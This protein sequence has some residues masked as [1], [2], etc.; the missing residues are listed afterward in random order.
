MKRS[1]PRGVMILE[2]MMSA[3]ARPTVSTLVSMMFVGL[4]AAGPARAADLSS[5]APAPMGTEEVVE[6][7]TG[8]YLRGDVGYIGYTKPKDFGF[9]LP[10]S[11]P[12]DRVRLDETYSLGGGIGY[13]FTNYLRADVTVDHRFGAEFSGTRPLI[14]YANGYVRDQADLE[15]TTILFNG[16]LDF[17]SFA[18]VTP[19][20]GAGIGLAGNRL[21]NISR[22]AYA[23]GVLVGSGFLQPH[24][25]NNFAWALMA[26]AAMNLGSGFQLDLGYRYMNLGD[27]RTKIDGPGDGIRTDTLTAHEVRLGARYMI[28]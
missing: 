2:W 3:L 7:G 18:G 10:D 6:I 16:Y 17:G 23:A 25:T 1:A 5:P 26:G 4:A 15:S 19:Y 22:E 27:A 13:A 9:G 8:W 11:Q 21:T 24:T 14:T 28:D 20:I 12:L